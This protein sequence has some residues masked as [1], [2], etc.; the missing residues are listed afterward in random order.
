[1]K[2]SS[3]LLITILFS[4]IIMCSLQ[5]EVIKASNSVNGIIN[6]NE[7]WSPTSGPWDLTGN[8]LIDS[9]VTVTVE[10]GSV[11][12]LNGYY[13]RV[14]GSLNIQQGVTLNMG[15]TGTNVGNIQV[16]GVFR[17]RGTPTDPI[18]FNGGTY[19][20]DSIFVPPSVSFV[21]FLGSSM[22][23]SEQTGSGCIIEY[24]FLNKT[25]V[26]TT[27]SIK[28][29]NNQLSGA[30]IVI[31]AASPVISNNV[32]SSGISIS[33]GSPII[34]NNNLNN[35]YIWI[36]GSSSIGSPVI[37][38]NV[39]SNTNPQWPFA[40]SAGIAILAAAY[41]TNGLILVEKNIIK[42]SSIGVDLI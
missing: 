31:A 5:V 15:V 6:S 27:S 4:S 35:G 11:V 7:S 42:G 17:V 19:S 40:T 26:T 29:S 30:G 23:W 9:G 33:G 8:V 20:W 41:N 39:I 36:D 38:S 25:G 10:A 37:T 16:N 34:A 24:A 1:M 13:I 14:N 12:N 3:L 2:N 32:I 28:F 22:A 21:T 18:K